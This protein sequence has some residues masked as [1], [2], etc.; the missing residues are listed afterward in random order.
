MPKTVYVHHMCEYMIIILPTIPPVMHCE[1][2]V[3]RPYCAAIMM[4]MAVDSSAA[5]PRAA[6]T[7]AISLPTTRVTRLPVETRVELGVRGGRCGE[8]GRGEGES[9]GEGVIERVG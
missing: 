4:T 3:G 8:G 2:D 1:D 5:K 9:C 7:L 6:E